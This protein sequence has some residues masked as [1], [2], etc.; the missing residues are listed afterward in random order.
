MVISNS[1]PK[2]QFTGT[3]VI[4]TAQWLPVLA[5]HHSKTFRQKTIYT[6]Q[7]SP[8]LNIYQIPGGVHFL[9]VTVLSVEGAVG[10][11]CGFRGAT[12]AS[13]GL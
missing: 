3:F 1:L 4:K 9:G 10:S 13:T 12:S 2:A 6:Q 11:S 5:P 7:S 8:H